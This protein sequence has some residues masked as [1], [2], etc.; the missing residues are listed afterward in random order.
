M[1]TTERK[2]HFLYEQ[3]FQLFSILIFNCAYTYVQFILNEVINFQIFSYW[4]IRDIFPKKFLLFSTEIL[5]NSAWKNI[6]AGNFC[7]L[8]IGITSWLL[9]L[10][11]SLLYSLYYSN[12]TF[13]LIAFLEFWV[14]FICLM[15]LRISCNYKY[16][17]LHV[18]S[19]IIKNW[20]TWIIIVFAWTKYLAFRVNHNG[21]KNVVVTINNFHCFFH[22]IFVIQKVNVII[23]IKSIDL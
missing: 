8:L 22:H 21:E 4:W 16:G 12:T 9:W 7:K 2:P 5:N 19:V 17:T 10:S 6:R 11:I 18:L 14:L 13:R 3:N 20:T 15:G 1:K 23:S